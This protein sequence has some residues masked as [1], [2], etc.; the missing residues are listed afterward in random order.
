MAKRIRLSED[1]GVTWNT[2]PGNSGELR[3]EAGEIVDTIFGQ[4]FSS[5]QP[6]LI[7]WSISSNALYK[8]FAGYVATIK[9]QGTSTV[10][11]AEAT[12]QV[13]ATQTY[14]ITDTARQILDRSV[15]PIILDNGAAVADA[16]IES[17]DYLFG[18]VTFVAGY[19]VTGPVTLDINFF[20]TTELC[21]ANSFTLTQTAEGV[22]ITDMCLAAGNNGYRI[23]DYG[24]KTVSLELSGFYNLSYGYLAQLR[25]RQEWIIE[26]NPDGGGQ[27][28]ARGFFRATSHGQSGTVGN[29]EEESV[30]FQLNVPDVDNLATPFTWVH[31]PT[32]TLNQAVITFLNAWENSIEIDAQ[33]LGDGTAGEQGKVIV[34]EASLT[35]GLEVM[36]EF[37]VT[38]QGTG[39]PTTV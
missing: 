7:G 26:L 21:G 2:L 5:T 31:Q 39:E 29:P 23:W 22:D 32:T 9:R 13:G 12:T 33:Y 34:T 19:V 38:L 30:T 20:P 1:L 4:D 28:V 27:T 11:A 36:N 18:R 37:S 10:A 8:G 15:V 35:G 16:D 17:I 6:G 14:E 24:L 3:N 25:S